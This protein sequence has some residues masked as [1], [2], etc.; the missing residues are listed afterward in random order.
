[1]RL[2]VPALL[3]TL[4]ASGCNA[5]QE[6]LSQWMDQQRHEQCRDDRPHFLPPRAAGFAPLVFCRCASTSAWSR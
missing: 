3:V 4:L 2:I 5:D 6:E 1:M